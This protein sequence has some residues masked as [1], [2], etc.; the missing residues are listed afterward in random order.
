VRHAKPLAWSKGPANTSAFIDLFCREIEHHPTGLIAQL[1]GPNA[2]A[3]AIR[4]NLE[5]R[6]DVIGQ[7]VTFSPVP[8]WGESEPDEKGANTVVET[9]GMRVDARSPVGRARVMGDQEA[10]QELVAGFI[11]E[12]ANPEHG[13]PRSLIVVR[14]ELAVSMELAVAALY[15]ESSLPHDIHLRRS[16]LGWVPYTSQG[17]IGLITVGSTRSDGEVLRAQ[18]VK[19]AGS[20]ADFA[21]SPQQV[22][23]VFSAAAQWARGCTASGRNLQMPKAPAPTG[24]LLA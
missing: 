3:Q 10:I 2:N 14:K 4:R 20:S 6:S 9:F 24:M 19:A 15:A 7:D 8:G 16:D 12:A 13:G 1:C 22:E 21:A 23:A 11:S 18:L 5:R 17:A